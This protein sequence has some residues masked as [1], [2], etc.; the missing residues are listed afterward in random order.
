VKHLQA[1]GR[2]KLLPKILRELK[3]LEARREKLAPSVEVASEHEAK[4]ALAEAKEFGIET[5]KAHVN[6]A[7]I[8][9]WRG[10]SGS[11][12]VDRSAK[13]GLIEIYRRVTG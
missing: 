10:R 7:L 5:T 2:T 8:K 11:S 3:V 13:N 9:G 12:L 1:T 6:H 4:R